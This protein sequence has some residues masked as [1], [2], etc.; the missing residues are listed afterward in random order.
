MPSAM[1]IL[2]AKMDGK[3]REAATTGKALWLM[4]RYNDLTEDDRRNLI[5]MVAT[6][7]GPN[8]IN[9]QLVCFG[10]SLSTFPKIMSHE[11][12]KNY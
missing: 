7:S 5:V 4:R 2:T 1:T 10:M 11:V 8:P 12:R 9:R 3:W 6:N